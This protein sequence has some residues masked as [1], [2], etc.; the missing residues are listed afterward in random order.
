MRV[1]PVIAALAGLLAAAPS[2]GAAA[3]LDTLTV[4]PGASAPVAGTTP[5]HPGTRYGLEVSGV[6]QETG[7][8]G[9]GFRYDGLYCYDGVGFDASAGPQCPHSG[10]NDRSNRGNQIAVQVGSGKA[11]PPDW[12][13]TS[14]ASPSAATQ[15]PYD[16]NHSYSV[17]F[18]ADKT[19]TLRA[20]GPNAFTPC[21]TCQTT[22]GGGPVVIKLFGPAPSG[23][24]GG[25]GGGSTPTTV[26]PLTVADGGPL[27]CKQG[28]QTP[29]TPTQAAFCGFGQ[30]AVKPAP[31]SGQPVNTSSPPLKPKTRSVTGFIKLNEAEV[32]REAGMIVDALDPEDGSTKFRDLF[33]GCLLF[34][35][36]EPK[37]DILAIKSEH[38]RYVYFVCAQITFANLKGEKGRRAHAA[39][40][41]AACHATWVPIFKTGRHVTRREYRRVVA[42]HNRMQ[43]ASCRFGAAG[44]TYSV[45]A[46]HRTLDRA[47]GRQARTAFIR[48]GSGPDGASPQLSYTWNAT[49]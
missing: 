12:F 18:Y 25:G 47:L 23:G 31:P 13:G 35:G 30:V 48:I 9:Y 29:A 43:K 7:P 17:P 3:L 1:T 38:E 6:F 20:G 15:V 21:P 28:E 24:G 14:S 36:L 11:A 40:A 46:R 37:A 44:M 42:A 27:A 32:D 49:R 10:S 45:V 41:A 26:K 33:E 39:G 8:E 5:L 4:D 19:G 16:P 2:A 22:F 34:G